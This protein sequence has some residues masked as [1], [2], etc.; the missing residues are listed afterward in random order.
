MVAESSLMQPGSVIT[1]AVAVLAVA[2]A[3]GGSFAAEPN[4]AAERVVAIPP[5]SDPRAR[6]ANPDLPA[7]R[8]VKGAPGDDY[9]PFHYTDAD[10]QPVGF[11]VDLARAICA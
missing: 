5:Y 4:P 1:K 11:A 3:A 7:G 9:P 6:L 8:I 10:G 2:F